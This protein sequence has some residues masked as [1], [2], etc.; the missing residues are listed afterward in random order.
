[1]PAGQLRYQ[2]LSHAS[3]RL[4]FRRRD[5]ANY[6]FRRVI[7]RFRR[8]VQPRELR[9]VYNNAQL[10]RRAVELTHSLPTATSLPPDTCSNHGSW[11][12]RP[13]RRNAATAAMHRTISIPL[14]ARYT[15]SKC[16]HFT[17]RTTAA[18][19]PAQNERPIASR[20]R[21]GGTSS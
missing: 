21:T 14:S 13:A 15:L 5:H 9:A 12:R 18:S 2:L 16:R 7:P 11:H 6:M 20:V 8:A 3:S 10:S 1:M 4:P 17:R 19:L